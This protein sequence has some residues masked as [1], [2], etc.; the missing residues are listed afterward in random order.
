MSSRPPFLLV[1]IQLEQSE[2]VHDGNYTRYNTCCL[3]LLLSYCC[4]KA[5]PSK[6]LELK[7]EKQTFTFED[8][9]SEPVPSLLR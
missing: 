4:I 6:V 3:F 9:A 8:V 7:E 2:N 1:M 5:V